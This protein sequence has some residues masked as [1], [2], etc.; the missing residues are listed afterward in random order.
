VTPEAAAAP[1]VSA[2]TL[3][4]RVETGERVD[5]LDTRNQ[6]E[7]DAWRIEGPGVRRTHVP[8]LTFVSARATGDAAS[9]VDAE[10]S[11]LVVCPEGDASAEVAATLSE[12]GVDAANLAG[13]MRA[14]ARVYRS[15]PIAADA[16]DATVLQYR[17]PASGCLAYLVAAD[18][19]ALIVDP[20]RAFADR[21][22]ADAGDLNADVSYVL[23]T[24][25]HADHFSGWG[26]VADAT[27]ATA[28]ISEAAAD[29][30]LAV[31]LPFET[32]A[33]GDT[34]AVGDCEVELLATPG[35]TTGSVSL[36]VDDLLLPGDALFLE[37][38][39]RPD[40]QRGDDD[41]PEF[42][43]TLHETLTEWL[44]DLP[45]RT[46]VAPGHVPPGRPGD[47]GT[48]TARLGALRDRLA[49]FS[50]DRE[51]FIERV[52]DGTGRPPAN[53]ETIVAVNLGRE[54]VDDE[55]A[56]ELELGPNNC[57]VGV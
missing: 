32:V 28:V 33:D 35:H 46:V 26:R 20:L 36:R 11:Y 23:D 8:Y 29:R 53:V 39:P 48:H 56:F 31:P 43:R 21:Y 4:D 37:G 13:G 30:D 9:L 2:E 3:A 45:D 14:W 15:G 52:V 40:L 12:D 19:D 6:D 34:L 10:R 25:V 51:A 47:D 27:G 57:A 44:A 18:G 41:A 7:V 5:V 1:E 17:R 22:P 49:A 42:A 50:T 55:T 54:T 24:H 16:T 38:A